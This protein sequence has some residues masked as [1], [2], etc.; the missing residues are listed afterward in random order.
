MDYGDVAEIKTHPCTWLYS[1][2]NN[3]EPAT[4]CNVSQPERCRDD[5]QSRCFIK[6]PMLRGGRL[7]QH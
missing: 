5:Y 4:P 2:S 6:D 1:G 7:Y 3:I